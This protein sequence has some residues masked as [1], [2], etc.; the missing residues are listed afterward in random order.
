MTLL[1]YL[2]DV[3]DGGE[4]AFPVADN[5]TFNQQVL[6]NGI[7][8]SQNYVVACNCFPIEINPAKVPDDLSNLKA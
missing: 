1:Y 2:N 8:H 6:S 3:E 7:R 5:E 4:T